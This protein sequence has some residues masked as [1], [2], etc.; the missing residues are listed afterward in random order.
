ML[1]E[2]LERFNTKKR[3][4]GAALQDILLLNVFRVSSELDAA[5]LRVFNNNWVEGRVE[6][7]INHISHC[8]EILFTIN[9]LKLN[10][11]KLR[12]R[13]KYL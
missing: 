3:A 10:S 6:A 7:R 5:K 8:V 12:R 4:A 13:L 9:E 1:A 11:T 2:L